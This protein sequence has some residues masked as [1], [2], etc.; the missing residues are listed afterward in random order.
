M[1]E[2]K[3]SGFL[4]DI[5]NED[6][7]K[8]IDHRNHLE[9]KELLKEFIKLLSPKQR[10]IC[11]LLSKGFTQSEISETLNCSRANISRQVKAI[12]TKVSVILKNAIS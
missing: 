11:F 3:S 7:Q 8:R 4:F 10:E 1:N 5:T 9:E 2:E 12:E 6:F